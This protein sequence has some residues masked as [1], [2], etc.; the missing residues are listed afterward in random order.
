MRATPPSPASATAVLQ[1]SG[2]RKNYAAVRPLRIKSLAIAPAER[3]AIAGIDAAGAEM[4]VNLVTGASLP[5]EGE[6]RV[7]GRSTADLADG[8]AWLA[9]LDSFGI[10]TERAVLLEAATLAQNLT[11]PFTLEIDPI[12]PDMRDRV[13]RLAEECDIAAEWMEQRAGELTP[14]VKARAPLAR[15]IALGPA[16]LLMEHPTAALQETERSA[17]GTVVARVCETRALAAL[18]MTADPEFAAVAAHRALTLE[19]ST[20]ALAPQK[21][22][23][24]F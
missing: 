24:W 21:K 4:I 16:L 22:R 23:R 18:M 11:L 14:A 8:D 1:I 3:V 15:A 10:V 20:G 2:I 13:G 9:S 5:D 12:A 19:P 7:F 17:F 6:I